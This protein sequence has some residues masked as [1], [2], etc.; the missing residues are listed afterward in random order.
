MQMGRSP[1]AWCHHKFSPGVEAASVVGGAPKHHRTAWAQ[2]FG[3]GIF[4]VARIA[5]AGITEPLAS[6]V[7]SKP[8]GYGEK[9]EQA[10]QK[11]YCYS[12]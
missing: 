10:S 6:P 3:F 7:A 2:L 5:Q 9:P 11:Q 8:M 12:G 4:E 1:L